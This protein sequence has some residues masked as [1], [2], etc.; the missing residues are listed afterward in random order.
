MAP[1]IQSVRLN[2]QPM[3]NVWI[4]HSAIVNGGTLEVEMGPEPSRWGVIP[5]PFRWR[6]GNSRAG[7]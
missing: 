4:P 1:Y 6:T 5:N 3:N 7:D 2:E